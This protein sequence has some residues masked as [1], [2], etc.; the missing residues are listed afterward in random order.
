MLDAELENP[1]TTWQRICDANT[2]K[3][4][5]RDVVQKLRRSGILK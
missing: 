4:L 2:G 1:E 3:L 5:T